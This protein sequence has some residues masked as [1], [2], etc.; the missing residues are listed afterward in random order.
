MAKR[1]KEKEKK[2][3]VWYLAIIIMFLTVLIFILLKDNLPKNINNATIVNQQQI[4]NDNVIEVIE[5][6]YVIED[7]ENFS[8]QNAEIKT[9]NNISYIN[10]EVKNKSDEK[11][12]QKEIIIHLYSETEEMQLAYTL[13]EIEANSSYTMQLNVIADLS[14]IELIE[15]M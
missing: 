2:S 15:I 10:I 9:E 7:F 1:M 8:F 5:E 13:P 3:K 6:K 14:D 4:L 12:Y 11:S